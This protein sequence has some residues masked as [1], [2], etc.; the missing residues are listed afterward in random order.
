ME[1]IKIKNFDIFVKKLDEVFGREYWDI[2]EDVSN[3]YVSQYFIHIYYPNVTITN[4]NKTSM[5]LKDF[6]VRLDVEHSGYIYR[7]L[8]G[9]LNTPS[10][11]QIIY[12]YHHSNINSSVDRVN[13][14][15][16][17]TGRN[18][19]K[20][21]V[22]SYNESR[23]EDELHMLLSYINSIVETES[24]AGVPYIKMERM[25]ITSNIS[26]DISY[27]IKNFNE[28]YNI[29]Y[30]KICNL[31]WTFKGNSL[32]I[33]DNEKLEMNLVDLIYN[34]NDYDLQDADIYVKKD[35]LGNYYNNNA[36]YYMEF[37]NTY[38]KDQNRNNTFEFKG[39]LFPISVSQAAEVTDT[40]IYIHPKIK[41]DA[42]AIIEKIV[43]EKAIIQNIQQRK[44]KIK[45][46]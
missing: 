5:Q 27:L 39:K 21:L 17:C 33:V 22:E 45:I 19:Y 24:L 14:K 25:I 26:N 37:I 3:E 38:I 32:V 34:N 1:N 23:S 18:H 46:V 8:W 44:N 7:Y 28:N 9:K 30:S 2:V 11:Q 20:T 41:Q 12:N 35:S 6:F 13:F 43:N 29:D 4:E 36:N 40:K 15:S 31:D 10:I 42:K 16:F